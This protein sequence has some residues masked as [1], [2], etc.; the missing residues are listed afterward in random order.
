MEAVREESFREVDD[1]LVLPNAEDVVCVED[2]DG[3]RVAL[4]GPPSGVLA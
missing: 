4:R 3:L 1:S 2:L